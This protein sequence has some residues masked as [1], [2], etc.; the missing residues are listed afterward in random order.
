MSLFNINAFIRDY[1]DADGVK[2]GFTNRA[3]RTLSASAVRDG[4]RLYVVLLNAPDRYDDAT[5]LLD[6]A[7]DNHQWP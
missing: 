1:P 2:T 5:A 4:K 3:G 6:W 7:F